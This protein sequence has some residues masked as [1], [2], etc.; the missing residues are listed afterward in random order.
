MLSQKLIEKLMLKILQRIFRKNTIASNAVL[1]ADFKPPLR[2]YRLKRDYWIWWSGYKYNKGRIFIQWWNPKK[3]YETQLLAT[4][5]E[6]HSWGGGYSSLLNDM[7]RHN[8]IEEIELKDLNK[9]KSHWNKEMYR[10][11][12]RFKIYL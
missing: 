6:H 8:Q 7:R 10:A 5:T 9:I 1:N 11:L 3:G 2:A 12:E 4:P